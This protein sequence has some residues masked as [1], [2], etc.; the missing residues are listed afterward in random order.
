MGIPSRAEIPLQP[1]KEPSM[2]KQMD[3]RGRLL[4]YREPKMEQAPDQTCGSKKKGAHAAAVCPW[5][6]N[7]CWRSLWRTI[8]HRKDPMLEM[9][10]CMKRKE[11]QRQCVMNT[12][13]HF[14]PIPLHHS[15][16]KAEKLG[17]KWSSGRRKLEGEDLLRFEFVSCDTTLIG[18]KLN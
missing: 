12:L 9:R 17:A 14:F 13:Q 6:S 2:L 7:P 8:F 1:L 10:R 4:P 5:W 3:A 16:E 15:G 11:Q 18:N